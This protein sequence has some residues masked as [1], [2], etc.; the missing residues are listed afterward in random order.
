M[1]RAKKQLRKSYLFQRL[2]FNRITNSEIE[3][4]MKVVDKSRRLLEEKYPEL[5]FHVLFWHKP[6]DR[7]SNAMLRAFQE[8][9]FSVHLIQQ[10]IPDYNEQHDQY[11]F[12]KSY[13][14]M[15]PLQH[16]QKHCRL[17]QMTGKRRS[18]CGY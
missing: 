7:I 9:D 1:E 11:R 17:R 3:I 18:H 2:F 16:E 12:G 14:C 6:Q 4:F 5:A 13:A 8:R 15:Q 10:I